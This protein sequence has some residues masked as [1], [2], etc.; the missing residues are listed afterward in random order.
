MLQSGVA[1]LSHVIDLADDQMDAALRR[2]EEVHRQAAARR[3]REIAELR[4]V[5]GEKEAALDELRDALAG[6]KRHAE[7]QLRQ[8]STALGERDTEVRRHAWMEGLAV[9]AGAR[10]PL[11][12]LTWL[13]LREESV[14]RH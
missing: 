11:V 3:E 10:C 14:E 1:R 7:A 6:H 4:G 5:L 9:C 2:A 13:T 8:Q 12:P